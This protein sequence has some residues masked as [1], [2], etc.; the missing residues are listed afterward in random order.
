[1]SKAA[2]TFGVDLEALKIKILEA[3]SLPAYRDL[4]SKSVFLV[5]ATSF[6]TLQTLCSG[7]S[8]STK[9]NK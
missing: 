5:S 6:E 3:K 9:D 1:M 8:S 4:P 2:I 7:S